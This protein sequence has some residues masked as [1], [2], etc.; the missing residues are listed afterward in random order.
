MFNKAA[1]ACAAMLM[2]FAPLFAQSPNKF[3]RP[4]V[5]DVQAPP[6]ANGP[7]L[8]VSKLTVTSVTASQV[9]YA[10]DI[11]N[12]GNQ[13]ASLASVSTQAYIY[14]GQGQKT[15]AGGALLTGATSLEA[16]KTI[17]RT[18]QATVTTTGYKK[19]CLTID[20]NNNLAETQEGDNSLCVPLE[21]NAVANNFDLVPVRDGNYLAVFRKD[22]T[23]NFIYFKIQNDGP[24]KCPATKVRVQYKNNATGETITETLA[25]P[26]ISPYNKVTIGVDRERAGARKEHRAAVRELLVV[27]RDDEE[28]ITRNR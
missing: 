26:A 14:N 8:V 16:G 27:R 2:A 4:D 1:I 11:T 12:T 22:E 25:V 9:K 15:A 17:T 24:I 18:I 3:P 7:N 5:P 19:L 13:T 28:A 20:F 23:P 6:P 10:F 21:N